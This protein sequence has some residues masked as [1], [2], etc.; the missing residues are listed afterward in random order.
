MWLELTQWESNNNALVYGVI[1]TE[2][3][4]ENISYHAE[5]DMHNDS[6]SFLCNVYD[7]K[8]VEIMSAMKYAYSTLEDPN[9][10]QMME[11]IG[12]WLVDYYKQSND[13]KGWDNAKLYDSETKT[14]ESVKDFLTRQGDRNAS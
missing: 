14:F 2:D 1:S 9:Y 3:V 6:G 10:E 8:E 11:V 7:F 13:T 12:E 5:F 4:R